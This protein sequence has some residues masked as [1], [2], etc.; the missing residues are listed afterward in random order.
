MRHLEEF[1]L[2]LRGYLKAIKFIRQHELWFFL[3][4]PTLLNI[5]ILGG[6]LWLGWHCSD[7]LIEWLAAQ[8]QWEILPD[9]ATST[10]DWLIL[11]VVKLLVVFIFLKTYTVLVLI[12]LLPVLG[13]LAEKVQ[14]I[15][16]DRPE[17]KFD[18]NLLVSNILRGLGLTL[19]NTAVELTYTVILVLIGFIFPPISLLTSV[20]VILLQSYF[21]GFGMIDLR[22][23]FLRF[24]AKKSR[25]VVWKHAGFSTGNGLGFVLMVFI[26]F[27]GILFAPILSVIGANIGIFELRADF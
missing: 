10:L 19:R 20:L 2:G 27:L 13:M 17:P 8:A 26:P 18:F 4:L 3:L 25:K 7:S 24:S 23:E 15:L 9:W 5:L 6:V 16:L 12:L 11:I 1:F 22:N 14:L 21:I